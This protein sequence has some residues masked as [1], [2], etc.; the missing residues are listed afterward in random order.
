MEAVAV[1]EPEVKNKVEIQEKEP[2]PL[3]YTAEDLDRELRIIEMA[4]E[5]LR[6]KVNK[7]LEAERVAKKKKAPTSLIELKGIWKGANF[8]EEEI[9]EAKYK[10]EEWWL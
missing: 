1:K 3:P 7:L 2:A 5:A 10:V 9:E 4:V 6:A 8:T